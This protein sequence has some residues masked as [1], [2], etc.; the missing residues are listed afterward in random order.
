MADHSSRPRT[1]PRRTPTRTERRI[2]KVRVL[3]RW[4]PARI[5][6]L[7]RPGPLNRAPGADP[8]RPG[9]PHAPGPGHRPRHTPLRTRTSRRA[10][11]RRHQE[12]RQHPRR[13]RTQGPRPGRR[14]QNP[15]RTPAT[16]TCTPP[17]TTTPAWPTARST[18]DEKKETATGFWTRAHAFFIQA[19]DH[20]RTRPD[21][22]RLL[23][24]LTRLARHRSPRPGSP[25][26]EPGPTGRRP[27]GRSNA[28]TAPC[29]TNGP[30]PGPTARRPNAARRSPMA[31][32]LQ[33]PPRTHRAERPATRQPRPQPLRAIH[34]AG[35]LVLP[36]LQEVPHVLGGAVE[37]LVA[38]RAEGVADAGPGQ[39]AGDGDA[40]VF[41]L[42]EA[43]AGG[44]EGAEGFG[45]AVVQG[46]GGFADDGAVAVLLGDPEYAE[47]SDAVVL[48]LGEAVAR[49]QEGA[50][51]FW[52]LASSAVLASR[53]TRLSP[54]LIAWP[55]MRDTATRSSSSDAGPTDVP[56]TAVA[57]GDDAAVVPEAKA[58]VAT[59]RVGARAAAAMSRAARVGRMS[60]PP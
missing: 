12:A 15:L 5:A 9:P 43:V 44:A 36:G 17:S 25:T 3:R 46:L 33:S 19:G 57:A 21:R 1:S 41:G 31:P 32:H 42:G 18:P 55:R 39:D 11:A 28:S 7:L 24:P 48:G 4:G 59:A 45:G 13:R 16:A 27:T 51:D 56:D 8:L 10:G 54:S 23:L 37:G 53:M 35:H 29:S 38:G 40:V 6:H 20:R 47:G 60:V 52:V 34:L 50:Q 2:I 49:V 30:T 58:G 14:P 26:S 22:Q